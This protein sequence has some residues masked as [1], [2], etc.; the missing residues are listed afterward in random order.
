MSRP[1]TPVAAPTAV[2]LVRRTLDNGLR[3]LVVPQRLGGAGDALRRGHALGATG[4]HG[5][6]HFFE[7]LMFQGTEH[8]PRAGFSHNIEEVGGLLNGT[9]HF[10]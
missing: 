4:P 8:I 5:F 1:G 2:G 9:T 10:D 6:A 3:V 7:H